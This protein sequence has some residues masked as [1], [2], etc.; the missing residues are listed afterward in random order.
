MVWIKGLMEDA[1]K[2]KRT[3]AEVSLSFPVQMIFSLSAADY[4]SHLHLHDH[5][6]FDTHNFIQN[7]L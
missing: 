3:S 2:E 7:D 4:S 1:Q 5:R 6:S